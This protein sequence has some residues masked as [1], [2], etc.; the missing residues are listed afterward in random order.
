M[1]PSNPFKHIISEI[2]A[3]R[4]APVYILS[5]EESYYIDLIADTLQQYVVPEEERDFNQHVYYGQDADLDDIINTARQYPVMSAR[6]LVMLREAQTL[7]NARQQLEGMEIYLQH[8]CPTTVLVIHFKGEALKETSRLV[9]SA[10]KVNGIIYSA[11]KTR[12]YQLPMHLRDYCNDHSLTLE[13]KA[14]QMLCESIGANLQLLFRE[15][16]KLRLALPEGNHVS[17]TADMVAANIG[18][19]KQYNVFELKSA[20]MY[21]DYEKC[22]RI[23]SYY[24]ANPNA[25]GTAPEMIS[26]TVFKA[27]ASLMTAHYLTDKSDSSL[28]DNLN[29]SFRNQLEEFRAGLKNYSAWSCL[30]IIHAIRDYDRNIKGI[31]SSQPRTGL[32][33]ELIYKIFTL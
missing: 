3:G 29:I 31:G 26:A 13:P 25:R 32:L 15:V 9:K 7:Q 24:A 19:S 2:R 14:A 27:F 30:R 22:M 16:E 18:V 21:R 6:K 20:L 1:A 28:R 12:D 23:A 4:L 8:P 17:I 11:A 5:G 33:I 10:K